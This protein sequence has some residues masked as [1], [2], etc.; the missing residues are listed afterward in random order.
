MDKS[1]GDIYKK[2]QLAYWKNLWFHNRK[3]IIAAIVAIIT[4]VYFMVK[5]TMIIRPDVTIIYVTRERI[6]EVNIDKI[7]KKY[8]SIISDCNGDG[9][10]ILKV[11]P[12]LME[13]DAPS[14]VEN[15]NGSRLNTEIISGESTLIIGEYELIEKYINMDGFFYEPLEGNYKLIYSEKGNASA[16]DI[17]Q[18]EFARIA[19]YDGEEPLCILVKGLADEVKKDKFLLKSWN[20]GKKIAD[21]IVLE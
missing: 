7:E 12:I 8:E 4:M 9:K 17:S 2:T 19:E 21:K 16:V 20:E 10:A 5:C 18:S 15:A 14:Q 11:V 13:K 6:A 1:Y 3:T